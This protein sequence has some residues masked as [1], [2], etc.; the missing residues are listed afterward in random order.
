VIS[1]LSYLNL[2]IEAWFGE[3]KLKNALL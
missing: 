3:D 2:E 1:S